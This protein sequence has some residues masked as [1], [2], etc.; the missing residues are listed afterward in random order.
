MQ[1]INFTATMNPDLE[2]LHSLLNA[3]PQHPH[4]HRVDMPY[5]L[6]STWQEHGCEVGLWEQR[7]ELV[8]WAV[9]QP[10]WW[11]LDYALHPSLRGSSLEKEIFVWGQAQM[12]SYAQRSG[13][14]FWGS[15]EFFAGTPGAGEITNHLTQLG[16]QKFDWSVIRLEIDLDRELPQ[17]KLPAG[18]AIRPLRGEAEVADYVRLHRAAFDSNKMTVAW[19]QRT[20]QHPAYKPEI[21][22]VAVTS[23]GT[24]AG[25]C[26]CW[27]WQDVG[28]FEP[29]GVHPDYQGLGLGRAL[30]LAALQQLRQH[31]ART[32]CVDHGSYNEK[33]INLSL[34]TGFTQT[35]DAWRYFLDVGKDTKAY[36]Q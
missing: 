26:I 20:L 15:V 32:V 21:D 8:A 6:T 12:K 10:P 35:N 5:R 27:L 28:Q 22:L 24:L 17:P 3:D 2:Q 14:E 7:D 31:G 25:F 4:I 13:E 36:V 19:R 34:Q 18:F 33:A 29:L 23:K 11:N 9:F 1:S 16:F 30:E